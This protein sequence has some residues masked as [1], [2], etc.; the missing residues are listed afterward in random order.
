MSEIWIFKNDW[1]K[2]YFAYT[3]IRSRMRTWEIFSFVSTEME[4]ILKDR[5]EIL[6]YKNILFL[7]L[8]ST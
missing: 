1:L 7:P 8:A 5:V 3:E 2:N 4:K 6:E